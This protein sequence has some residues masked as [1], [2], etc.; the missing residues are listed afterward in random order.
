MKTIRILSIFAL[1][2]SLISTV[3]ASDRI[4]LRAIGMGRTAV[5]ATRGTDAIGINP[6]N[7]AI[8]DIGHFNLSLV[9]SSFRISTELFTYDI[10]QK[11][12]TGRDSIGTDGKTERVPYLLTEQDKANIR[13][14]LPDN[15]VTSV[16]VESMIAGVSFETALLGGIGFAV[17]EHTGVNFAFSRDFFDMVYL[18]GLPSNAKYVFDGTS[19]NAWWYREY[20]VSYGRKLPVQISFLNDLYVG[21]AVK[22]IRGYGVFQTTKNSTSIENKTA[23]SDTGINSIIG[24]FD[25]LARRSGVDFFNNDNDSSKKSFTPLPDP[26][27]HGTGFDL[28]ISAEFINGLRVGLSVTD[29]GKITWD[30]N[31][32]ETFGGGQITFSGYTKEIEDS[33]KNV[34][35]GKNRQGESFST[36]LPTVL[37]IGATA[38]SE[39]LPFLKFLPGHLLLAAEY[40]QGFNESLGNTTK[41]RLSL[42]AE[43]RIIPFLPLRTGL[44]LGGGDKLRWAF[45]FGL[46]FRYFSLDFATDNFG[47]FFSPKSFQVVSVSLGMKVRV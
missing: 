19:F 34:I 40:A 23:L 24:N 42:G 30:R 29:I 33:A 22:F 10:Y 27:G 47:I 6:A 21:A 14:Q 17:I 46:D 41:P 32:M 4:S 12:F 9:Q 26:V 20:N 15:P 44:L 25:F 39:K 35:K 45:G 1:V 13:N 36:S 5:A 38:E 16:S 43:Y 3:S 31:V 37:R 2:V 7:I 18:Q 11:Y 28:G 8:P